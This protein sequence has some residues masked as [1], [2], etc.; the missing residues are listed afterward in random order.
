MVKNKNPT[1]VFGML[2]K[3]SE[4]YELKLGKEATS[5]LK[6]SKSASIENL[7]ITN[8]SDV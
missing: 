5:E 1:A 4:P 8:T 2:E 6:I 7:N 3:A